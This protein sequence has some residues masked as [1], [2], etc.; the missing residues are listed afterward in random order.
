MKI[1]LQN[2]NI[3]FT[4]EKTSQLPSSPIFDWFRAVADVCLG[5][6]ED[7]HSKLNMFSKIAYSYKEM[8]LKAGFDMGE[9][10]SVEIENNLL[11]VLKVSL[12][13][14]NN[15]IDWIQFIVNELE[16]R[17]LLLKA[18]NRKGDIRD[19]KEVLK[20]SEVFRM[21]EIGNKAN[22]GQNVTL[23]TIHSSKGREFDCVVLLGIQEGEIP[24]LGRK[25]SI[26][27]RNRFYVACTRAKRALYIVYADP[28][29]IRKW[30]KFQYQPASPYI[31]DVKYSLRANG[32]L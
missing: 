15:A 14:E 12:K 26:S 18:G 20:I 11:S 24:W 2:C 1:E 29:K 21:G 6:L 16:I 23:T 10:E 5:I 7:N 32:F 30:G 8:Y 22:D 13:Y 31:N 25:D 27:F 3:R 4:D 28:L 17:Q 9:D 19:I